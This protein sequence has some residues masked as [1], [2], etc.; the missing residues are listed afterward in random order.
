[1]PESGT[2]AENLIVF[3]T[4]RISESFLW[5]K[6]ERYRISA[7]DTGF[8]GVKHRVASL[9]LRLPPHREI[10]KQQNLRPNLRRKQFATNTR[11][12]RELVS[13]NAFG[14]FVLDTGEVYVSEFNLGR[15]CLFGHRHRMCAC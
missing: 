9:N 3:C 13:Y 14:K 2:G 8:Y 10:A 12:E 1:M 7:K 11:I 15:H 4:L 5:E 6:T